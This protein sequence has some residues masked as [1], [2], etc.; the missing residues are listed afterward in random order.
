MKCSRCETDLPPQT[1][2]C[3]KCG[4][5]LPRGVDTERIRAQL[6]K[7]Q[8]RLLDLTKGNPLLGINRSRVSK[9]RVL[10]PGAQT[11]F[12]DFVVEERTLKMPR[13]E[14]VAQRRAANEQE[15]ATEP[16]YRLE[17]GDLG[18]E[19]TLPDLHRRLRRIYDNARTTVEE[20]GVTTLHL[21]FGILRW[22]DPALGDSISPLW[23]V[24]C[25]LEGFGPSAPM[26]LSMADEEM[27]L[28]PALELY[29]R[30]RHRV[31][32]SVLPEEPTPD[33]LDGF[34]GEIA[35]AVR[36]HG[37]T[38]APE[39]WLSTYSFESLVIY[40]DLRTMAETALGND[41]VVALARAAQPPEGSEGLGEE[42]LDALPI[43]DRVPVPVLPTDSSQ[44]KALTGARTG[45]HL[46]IHGPPGTGKSQTI[47]NLIA[48]AL[49]QKKTVLFVSAKMAALNVVHDRLAQLGLD[50][51]CLEA[52]S[53]KAG[54]VKI[55]EELKRTLAAADHDGNGRLSE[56]LADL[57]RTRDE[58]NAYVRELHERRTRLGLSVYQVIGKVETLRGEADLR[59]SL[60]WDDPS[61]VTRAELQAAV[62]ALADLGSQARVFDGRGSHPWRGLTVELGTPLRR[63]ALETHLATLRG[64]LRRFLGHVT[65]L[66]VLVGPT[67]QSLNLE[68]LRALAPALSELGA[69]KRLPPAWTTREVEE[70]LATAAMLDTAVANATEQRAKLS[71]Y[72]K[73]LKV[74]L[75]DA[76]RLLAPVTAEFRGWT[77]VCRPSYWRWRGTVR[78]HLTQ[79]ARVDVAAL[80]SYLAMVRRLRELEA[81]FASHRGSL[82]AEVGPER[83]LA[84]GALEAAAKGLRAAA[85][86]RKVVVAV[87]LSIAESAPSL[88]DTLRRES[89]S[90]ASLV[91]DAALQDTVA[92][93]D[94]AWPGGFLE[95][96]PVAAAPM[97]TALA[98]C[99]EALAALPRIQEWVVLQR[100]LQKCHELNLTRF[101]D[102][103]GSRS[104]CTARGAFERRFYT[105][106]TNAALDA[107]PILA[108]FAGVRREDLIGRFR[109][110]DARVRSAALAATRAVAAEPARRI[111]AAHSGAGTASEVGVLRRELEKRRRIKP[112]RKLF[113]E[114]PNVLQALKPCMLMSPLSVS[115]F[116]KPGSLA[117]DL[118][119]FDEASQLPTQEAIP[120]ILRAKQVVVAGDAKQLPPTSFFKASVIFDEDGEAADTEEFEPLES[121]LNDCVAVFPVF[122]QAHLRWHYRSKD[123]RLIQFSNH[124]FY[125]DKPLITFPSVSTSAKDCGVRCVYVPEGIWDRGGSRTN[126]REAQRVAEVV[127]EQMERHPERSM[128]V[129]GMNV[130]QREAIE[131]ALDELV[132][133]RPELAPLLQPSRPEP[134]FIKALEN[135]QGDERD[136][137]IISVGYGKSSTGAL[138]FN[139]GPLNQ[140]GGERRLNVLVTR[141]RW[142][143]ILVSSLRSPELAGV[144]PNN[145]GAVVLRD[146]LAYAERGGELPAGPTVIT[147]QET[148]DF[149]D[150]VAEM[151]RARNLDVDQQVGA[152]EYRIDLAIRDPRDR[153]RYV[154]GIEC[155]G[156]TYHSAKTARDR[157]L[158]REEVLRGQGWR[159]YRIWSTDWFRDR[160][161]AIAGVLRALE[162]ALETPLEASVQ[163]PPESSGPIKESQPPDDESSKGTDPPP[164]R[165][166]SRFPRGE[167]YQMY[168]GVGH[169]GILLNHNR[170][171]E[172]AQQVVEIVNFEGPIH[173]ELLAERLK[174]IN[175]VARAG[176]NIQDNVNRATEI[177][178]RAGKVQR[179]PGDFLKSR[180]PTRHT[181]RRPGDGVQRS[182]STVPPEEIERAV[183]HV[184]EDQFGFQR[185]ALPRQ[186][187][188]LFGWER[189]SAGMAELVG[190][191]IDD[192]IARKLLSVSGYHVYLA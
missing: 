62:D 59:G 19:A 128:G 17:P 183:L 21:T 34:L 160:E 142:Q 35:A 178:I 156:A 165:V 85:A 105:A 123:E 67:A 174:E 45:G 137:M 187:G 41:I 175:S 167:P 61:Q 84:V 185:D 43:P 150:T 56:P 75:E 148:N 64:A 4:L 158:L 143:T 135:V 130:T 152:S 92:A 44:L 191:V 14:R 100:T 138:S 188:E 139:F 55:V 95:G 192:L 157:D 159:L 132:L 65:E 49:G 47:T 3:P 131:E 113:A 88:T 149:E 11:L 20:R 42:H 89:R 126:R 190:T 39:I 46:V 98:R 76:H 13:V 72:A 10:E 29:L 155:D 182:V 18:F 104:A 112:L 23:F 180:G 60:P 77:R 40:Q 79:Q 90:L 7:W 80:R 91:A 5:L 171:R 120:A 58:L 106:W 94:A 81:W 16:E 30:E 110:L 73:I 121:V 179:I 186:I 116:L 15:G 127:V 101:L 32:L 74:P 140:E 189:T 170:V 173:T 118:V 96:V 117:F 172:L 147:D 109:A 119:V 153:T 69:V 54:K 37:W 87:G 141:A 164:E 169:R 114:I 97:A 133:Q 68:S 50:R 25:Q 83:I 107:S 125:R 102:A 2:S 24:P 129:V 134:F 168:R 144:N 63:E 184:V 111:A 115:T 53:T 66:A 22:Q 31:T 163:A 161:T 71:E 9:L 136:T 86:F 70:L 52:H 99:E 151:L 38:V 28:N 145:R 82:S 103:L 146:F 6:K 51:F 26:R 122:D 176:H 36:E 33:A 78:S 162:R 27:Q 124:A 8:E 154:L 108:V 177:A 93:I 48:D 1:T 166:P 12:G 57:V 181:F